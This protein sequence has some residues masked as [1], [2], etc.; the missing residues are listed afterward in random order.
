MADAAGSGDRKALECLYRE[1]SDELYHIARRLTG[2]STDANDVVHDV[3]GR[4]PAALRGYDRRRPLRPW[5]H[6]VTVR[7]ALSQLRRETRRD[8]VSMPEDLVDEATVGRPSLDFIML[9][10][11]LSSLPQGHRSVIVL[12]EFQGYSHR[13]IGKLLGISPAASRARLC[14]AR[15]T[16]RAE[17][18]DE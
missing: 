12:K 9:E 18:I 16:L 5:M 10:R 17:M 4:L 6:A 13:E 7:E 1:Y 11:A 2:S 15:M 14:R 3:F 8:E